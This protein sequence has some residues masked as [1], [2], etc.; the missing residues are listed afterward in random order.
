MPPPGAGSGAGRQPQQEQQQQGIPFPLVA[1]ISEMVCEYLALAATLE[2]EVDTKDAYRRANML[3]WQLAIILPEPMY[4]KMVQA[5]VNPSVDNNV[6]SIV[7]D[8]RNWM[9]M[10]PVERQTLTSEHLPFHAPGIGE[11][12][13]HSVIVSPEDLPFLH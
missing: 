8:V 9:M 4:R 11:S 13:T 12:A 10:I 1:Q 7:C 3:A 2:K 5:L 6:L